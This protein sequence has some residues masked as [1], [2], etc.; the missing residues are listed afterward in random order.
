[1]ETL[2]DFNDQDWIQSFKYLND[3]LDTTENL[4][5]GFV[6]EAFIVEF[7]LSLRGWDGFLYRMLWVGVNR[8]RGRE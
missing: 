6:V 2:A 7:Q 1:M 4:Q 8:V 5:E 3:L